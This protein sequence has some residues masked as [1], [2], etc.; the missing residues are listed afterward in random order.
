MKI[1]IAL[2]R[3][4]ILAGMAGLLHCANSP[5]QAAM[6]TEKQITHTP[7]NHNLDNND[8][9]SPDQRFLC[10]D[11]REFVGYGIDNSQSVEK[12]E[13]A[14]GKETILV[15]AKDPIIGKEAAPGIGAATYSPISDKVILI[16]GP[17]VVEVPVRGFYGKP[18]RRGAE[19]PGDGSGKITWVDFRDVDKTRNTI[20]GAQRGG[21][22]RHEY[23]FDGKRIGFT[24]DDFLCSEYDRNI[25]YMIEH[26]KA[27][28]GASHYFAVL[29]KTAPMGKSKPGEIEKAY[30]DS[31]IGKEG[32][33]R[34][35]IGKVRNPDGETYE[36]S[37]FVVDIPESVDITTADSGGPSRY[38][39]PPKGLTIRRLTQTHAEGIVRGTI[40]GDRIAYYAKAADGTKQIFII[41]SDGSD[42][43]DKS[44]RRPIQAT[45]FEHGAGACVRWHPTG[46]S[47]ACFSNDGIA[48]TCVKPGPKFGKSVFLTAQGDNAERGALVWSPDGK[49]FAYNRPVPTKD[50]S[51][52]IV[53][54]YD[55]KDCLQIFTIDFPDSD[56]DGIPDGI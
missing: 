11:T 2:T 4:T 50:E 1:G 19:V 18:N 36:E 54:T 28:K 27:P 12:V 51:G 29:L 21:T 49:H 7:K 46:N 3:F 5:A 14:T 38:P 30:S 53:K 13:I 22:H 32:F 47:I 34:A 43:S 10:Y 48:V 31:W 40:Q 56:N 26:P 6:Q 45:S 25:G 55:G 17:L 16:H 15:K 33:M 37:L 41:A 9:Y 8:N 42:Q 23:S 24:Y 39:S 20:P 52:K 35:F 44:N